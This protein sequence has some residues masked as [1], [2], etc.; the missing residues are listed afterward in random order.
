V[1][2][3]FST[4]LT[5]GRGPLASFNWS[6][7]RRLDAGSHFDR[8]WKGTP[9]PTLEEVLESLD[10]RMTVNVE[11]KTA[12][13]EEAWWDK[14]LTLVRG[15]RKLSEARRRTARAEAEPLARAVAKILG[16]AA[17]ERFVISSFD[18]LALEAVGPL[19]P[20]IPLGFL[21]SPTVPWDTLALMRSIAHQAWHPHHSE[22]ITD[23][24]AR[25]KAAGRRVNVWTVN[26]SAHAVRLG[27]MGVD[28][29]ITNRPGEV[30]AALS[31]TES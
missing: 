14:W 26:D 18:P 17:P 22:V 16:Q 11:M 6:D 10:S 29:V 2:S 28:A 27:Q 4:L 12:L 1:C 3:P 13:S 23:A 21:H 9:I 15:P 7:L 8:G 19:V 24:L 30:L 20:K 5:D 31:P 25:Q